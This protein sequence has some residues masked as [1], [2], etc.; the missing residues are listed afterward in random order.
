MLD[1]HSY[2]KGAL[3]LHMLRRELGDADFFHGLGHYLK[4][5]AYQVVETHDLM[6]AIAE[7]TGRNVEP[8]FEQWVFKPGHPVIS[9]SWKWDEGARKLLVDVSQTQDTGNGTPIYRLNLPIG[10][11]YQGRLTQRN[12]AITQASQQFSMDFGAEPDAVLLDPDHDLLIERGDKNWVAGKVSSVLRYAPSSIDR[13]AA[14]MALLSDEQGTESFISSEMDR[15]L[16]ESSSPMIVAVL[17]K[18][19]GIKKQG[20]RTFLRGFLKHKDSREQSAAIAAIAALPISDED[21]TAFRSL[22]TEKQPY[23]VVT[24]CLR[25]LGGWDADGNLETLRRALRIDSHREIVRTT[26]LS[27]LSNA[28]TESAVDLA[29]AYSKSGKARAVRKAAADALVKFS[30]WS[31]KAK[32]ALRALAKDE[33]PQIRS[34]T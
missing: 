4:K 9:Y 17:N 30:E 28:K 23:S 12:F 27:A 8:F 33:D 15:V 18:V 34:W 7:S 19:A 11:L 5:H 2:P 1:S 24:A 32:E 25:A 13:Q 10:I 21:T 20:Y 16:D 26:A 6:R 14:V 3:I 29:I 31:T 22:I